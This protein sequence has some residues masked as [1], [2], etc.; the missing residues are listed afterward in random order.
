MGGELD[1]YDK[2]I[3]YYLD[4]NA[5]MPASEIAKKINLP[6]ETVNYRIK[7]LVKN[8]HILMFY[9]VFDASVLGYTY[10]K[11]FMKL[12]KTSPEKEKEI[13]AVFRKIKSCTNLRITEGVFYLNFITMQKNPQGLKRF[14]KK[15]NERF[16]EA[17]L[18][19]NIHTIT[20][21]HRINQKFL[22]PGPTEKK[23]IMV[24]SPKKTFTPDKTDNEIIKIISK[25][26]RIKLVELAHKIKK[27][28]R[29]VSYHLKKMEKKGFIKGYTTKLNLKKIGRRFV[30]ICISLKNTKD[31]LGMIEFF[32]QTD[33]CIRA[34]EVTG[35]YD[36]CI[37]LCVENTEQV[38]KLMERFKKKFM[39][40]YVFYDMADIYKNY[41]ID[42]SPL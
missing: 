5:R 19:K 2:K 39:K 10:Y 42:W 30:E 11:V 9:P 29:V 34:H 41:I 8:K 17:L 38:R 15:F 40:E 12:K 21:I 4:I 31:T 32:D 33:T 26:G 20:R 28:P 16:G 37:E 35:M 14:I 36:V 3:L 6:K 27:N 25:Q 23:T 24:G 7:R 13:I 18:Q 22:F 1:L